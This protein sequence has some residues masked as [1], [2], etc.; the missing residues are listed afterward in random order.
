MLILRFPNGPCIFHNLRGFKS[1][2]PLTAHTG[3]PYTKYSTGQ[4]MVLASDIFHCPAFLALY[5]TSETVEKFQ[6][7]V[8]LQ[9]L[10]SNFPARDS[11][12]LD[13]SIVKFI[14]KFP[15]FPVSLISS[16]Y[17]SAWHF[18]ELTR[19]ASTDQM[20]LPWFSNQRVGS[21][22]APGVAK[23]WP[24]SSNP[25]IYLQLWGSDG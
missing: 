25:S 7:N 22:P 16:V 21:R 12:V 2:Q 5:I 4:D 11:V 6:Y 19:V 13:F 3:S 14:S 23:Q 9:P 18:T 1:F 10:Q 15:L 8:Y 20:H 17:R 24:S